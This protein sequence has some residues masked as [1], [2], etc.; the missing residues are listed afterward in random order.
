[1]RQT[2]LKELQEKLASHSNLFKKSV[3]RSLEKL[4]QAIQNR[5]ALRLER[6][7]L[8]GMYRSIYLSLGETLRTTGT[9]ESQRDIF[10]LTEEEIMQVVLKGSDTVKTLIRERKKEFESYLK[11]EVPNRIVIPSPPGNT[12]SITNSNNLIGTSCYPGKVTG[13]AILVTGPEDN[14]DVHGKIVCALRTDPG[15]AA[16]FPTCKAVLIEKGSALSHSVILL[17][18]FEIPTIINI[19]G[20]TKKTKSGQRLSV[21]ATTGEIQILDHED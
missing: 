17:R 19:S 8:F 13:E 18:E 16:L 15:W 2:A 6:T 12:S 21:D 7:R 5:E 11:E 4:Q 3:F 9:I 1:L 10:Y 14:L 20:L